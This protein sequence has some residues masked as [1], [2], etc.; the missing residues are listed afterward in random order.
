MVKLVNSYF[1]VDEIKENINICN[2]PKLSITFIAIGIKHSFI[3][4]LEQQLNAIIRPLNCKY[5]HAKD[6]YKEKS[7][8]LEIMNSLT[9]L[10]CSYNL[11]CFQFSF[12]KDWL[13][14]PKLNALKQI[15]WTD[16][17]VNTTNYEQVAFYLFYHCLNTY[18][19]STNLQPKYRLV[20]HQ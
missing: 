14:H 18:I 8:N 9:D 7:A 12:A 2:K 3:N 11:H 5:F 10:S 19:P 1:F 17:T 13:N 4:S 16:W 6:V 15:K 20:F